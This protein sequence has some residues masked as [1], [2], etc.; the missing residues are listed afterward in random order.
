MEQKII[1][2]TEECA[3][4]LEKRGIQPETANRLGWQ[5]FAARK[6]G[7]IAIP[8]YRAGKIVNHKYR[9][10]EKL[11]EGHNFEQ[12]KGGEQCFYN[13][14]AIEDVAR[15]NAEDQRNT[16][17]VI[18]EG[19]MDCAI[20][21]QCGF[22]AVS[23][24]GGAPGQAIESEDSVKFDFLKD[25]PKYATA[26]LA[27]DDDPAGQILRQELALRLG[28]HRCKWV[29]YP[30]G[31]KDLNEVFIKYGAKGVDMV[32][33]EKSKFMNSGGLFKM[34]E[35]PAVEDIPALECMIGN[36]SDM[37]KFRLGDLS[38]W[39][40]IPSHGKT[41]WVNCLASTLA[42][43]YGW[44]ACFGSFEQNPRGDHQRYLRTY[45][46][47]KPKTDAHGNSQWSPAEISEADAWVEK[48]FTFIVPDVNTEDMVTLKWVLT[49]VRAAITQHGAKL[50]II[51]PWNE[52]DHD[53]PNG[54]SLTEYT[55]FA[56][57]EFK[58]LAKAY[59]VHVMIVA[60][61]AKMEK[62]KDGAYGVPTLYD[63]SDSAHWANKCDIGGIVHRV[64]GEENQYATLIRVAKIRYWN[65]IG[66]TGDKFLE[67]NP[68]TGKYIDAPDFQPKKKRDITKPVTEKEE[69]KKPQNTAQRS[70]PYKD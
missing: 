54:M 13:L 31:C 55:G 33:K 7:W 62:N 48:Y 29:Q 5:T 40:G 8:F 38:V 52:L 34:S 63:V 12:D 56:I 61:P 1:P 28:W 24:P 70:L 2:L 32:L 49:R 58:R 18:T 65:V 22:L 39:T 42:R 9:R 59:M 35:L 66:R 27:V 36:V 14:A 53:R 51:D 50:I 16:P 60:H 19:E 6:G 57:K 11:A 17:L 69:K 44:K 30:K 43:E 3:L 68:D 21:L 45:Y 41:T 25:F 10:I 26:T 47:G 4:L 15:L 37:V 20:A 64:E 67:Y 46:L 23:V